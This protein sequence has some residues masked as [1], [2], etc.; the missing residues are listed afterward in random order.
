MWERGRVFPLPTGEGVRGLTLPTGPR[1]PRREPRSGPPRPRRR[2][3]RRTPRVSGR[4]PP[5][6][7]RHSIEL[8]GQYHGLC[9]NVRTHRS[10]SGCHSMTPS[11]S[12]YPKKQRFR[13][14]TRP[15]TNRALVQTTWRLTGSRQ[16]TRPTGVLPKTDFVRRRSKQAPGA[17]ETF[18]DSVDLA[19][20]V[21][22][23]GPMPGA[24]QPA[25]RRGAPR[26]H[27]S[28]A[29]RPACASTSSSTNTA[30]HA[31]TE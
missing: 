28:P 18:G 16:S 5:P 13:R 27:L 19:R 25:S 21:N 3:R 15:P 23:S 24:L 10:S 17:K 2:I 31:A 29:P 4:C 7:S 14:A 9:N 6:A 26:P 22:Q 11:L 1:R 8:P 30:A 12:L 20:I